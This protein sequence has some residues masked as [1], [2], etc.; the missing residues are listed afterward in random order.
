M[1]GRAI[2]QLLAGPHTQAAVDGFI[3][4]HT[5]PIV[6][7]SQITFVYRGGADAVNLKHW[8]YGLPSSQTLAKVDGVDLW[9]LTLGVP[10]KSRIE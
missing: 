4:T 10:P 5:F 6:E 3:S 8:V 1:S 7:G 2:E 9:H